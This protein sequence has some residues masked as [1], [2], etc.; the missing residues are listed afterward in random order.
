VKRILFAVLA[1]AVVGACAAAALP[2]PHGPSVERDGGPA[3]GPGDGAPPDGGDVRTVDAAAL[4]AELAPG[5]RELEHVALDADAA[6]HEIAAGDADRCFRIAVVAKSIVDA[7][8]ADDAGHVLATARGTTAVLGAK[9][10]VCLRR[11]HRATIAANGLAP[12]AELFVW[13]AP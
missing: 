8:L 9:G 4:G 6:L 12:N 13:T 5:M 11:G 2:R 1:V 10:P 7:T 3:D